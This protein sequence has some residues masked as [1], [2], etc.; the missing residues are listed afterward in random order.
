MLQLTNTFPLL[1]LLIYQFSRIS[2]EGFI[3]NDYT[4]Q[5]NS[6]SSIYS[7]IITLATN[8]TFTG[9]PKLTF[10]LIIPSD[11]ISSQ[12]V[13]IQSDSAQIKLLDFNTLSN[14]D[15]HKTDEIKTQTE[16]ANKAATSTTY[17]NFILSAGHPF[18]LHGMMLTEMIQLLKFLEIS[19]PEM[20]LEMFKGNTNLPT[21]MF[22]YKFE[23]SIEDIRKIPQLYTYYGVSPYFLENAGEQICKNLVLL[24]IGYALVVFL[25]KAT[26]TSFLVKIL[27]VVYSIFVWQFV[28]FFML[29]YFQ[30]FVFYTI[31]NLVFRSESDNGTK[32]LGVAS[33]FF[34]IEIGFMVHLCMILKVLR[35]IKG[36]QC[37]VEMHSANSNKIFIEEVE[38]DP[39]SLQRIF[40]NNEKSPTSFEA[41]K[42]ND[43]L[44]FS[45]E[46]QMSKVTSNSSIPS[47]LMSP[48]KDG[49][50]LKSPKKFKK[51]VVMPTI[52]ESQIPPPKLTFCQKIK[53]VFLFFKRVLVNLVSF[54]SIYHPKNDTGY[55]S[56]YEFLHVSLK[57]DSFSQS[58]Y[59]F[60][61][62]LRL[63][64]VSWLIGFHFN[65]FMQIFLIN[66]VNMGFI[67]FYLIVRP[68][69]SKL[70]FFCS[71]L[72]EIM[73]E[74]ALLSALAIAILDLTGDKTTNT[75][76]FFGWV[77]VGMNMALLCWICLLGIIKI[78]LIL[79]EKR[80][81]LRVK[82]TDV[83]ALDRNTSK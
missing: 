39:V 25:E 80:K 67:I 11:I 18:L 40:F 33:F 17:T 21:F 62:Y 70:I 5:I 71:L 13:Q 76:I 53:N 19:Y 48:M 23:N 66:I 49:G 22:N 82:T 47:P 60:F 3:H 45:M 61:D 74:S 81:R 59:I 34:V 69:H 73:T 4:Y 28:L 77:I 7:F 78:L 54:K 6:T 12:N 55:M 43:A 36:K 37:P 20:V 29:I 56:K 52:E 65:A 1:N 44:P 79:H 68:Y 24:G 46:K 64:I 15:K 14:D 32:N 42:T 75:R 26:S 57:S 38:K 50:G 30:R 31:S 63:L 35:S 8:K 10:T 72:S 41:I 58:Y 16:N 51:V 27:N 83:M 2:I 9:G